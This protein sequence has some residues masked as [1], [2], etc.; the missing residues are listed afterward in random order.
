MQ[1]YGGAQTI[2][3]TEARP[4]GGLAMEGGGPGSRDRLWLRQASASFGRRGLASPPT[5]AD[6]R[7]RAC[8]VVPGSDAP[9]ESESAVSG[10]MPRKL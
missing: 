7:S 2:C 5:H 4:G 1:G 9:S 10:S 3:V 6:N 8:H